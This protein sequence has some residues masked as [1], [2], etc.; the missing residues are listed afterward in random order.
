MITATIHQSHACVLVSS[1]QIAYVSAVP[2]PLPPSSDPDYPD[3]D[4][5]IERPTYLHA[6][7]YFVVYNRSPGQSPLSTALLCCRH[8][9]RTRTRACIHP[10]VHTYLRVYVSLFPSSSKNCLASAWRE[11]V[12]MRGHVLRTCPAVGGDVR[13]CRLRMAGPYV[14]MRACV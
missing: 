11:V 6:Y 4:T 12:G 2:S 5:L 3:V 10:T 13:A 7:G 14:C 8:P 9:G 1:T